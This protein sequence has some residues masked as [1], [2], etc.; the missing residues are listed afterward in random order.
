[1][2]LHNLNYRRLSLPCSV[3]WC[4]NFFVL[5]YWTSTSCNFGNSLPIYLILGLKWSGW[6]PPPKSRR[7]TWKND[8]WNFRS[9]PADRCVVIYGITEKK[10]GTPNNA[11]QKCYK[12]CSRGHH[13]QENINIVKNLGHHS[14]WRRPCGHTQ[15]EVLHQ[16][17]E[18]VSKIRKGN[19]LLRAKELIDASIISKRIC[20][21]FR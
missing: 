16:F 4:P 13:F 20:F 2:K 14:S 11:N 8:F 10:Q 6:Y 3:V 18:I 12:K 17:N 15:Q 19:N 1:M 5:F 21:S 7:Q 9:I